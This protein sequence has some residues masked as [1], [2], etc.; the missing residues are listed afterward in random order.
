MYLV[1]FNF[2]CESFKLLVLS[3]KS[4][5]A[6]Q[7]VDDL[8][9]KQHVQLIQKLRSLENQNNQLKSELGAERYLLV[10]N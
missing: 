4:R 3:K 2:F 9:A 1:G 10:D 5:M 7:T 6:D 8:V